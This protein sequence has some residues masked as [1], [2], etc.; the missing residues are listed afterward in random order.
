MRETSGAG[1]ADTE[2]LLEL[3]GEAG[4]L[5]DLHEFRSGLLDLLRR[6]VPADWISV[7]DIGPDPASI[8]VLIDP[9]FPVEDHDVFARLAHENPLISRHARTGDG[10]AYRFSDVVTRAELHAL[11]LYREFYGRI[12]LEHQVAFALPHEQN[13][14]LGVALS[15][16]ERDFSDEEVALLNRARPFLIQAYRNAIA[17]SNLSAELRIALAAQLPPTSG[18]L[19]EQMAARRIT[20]RELEVLRWAAAGRTDGDIADGLGISTRTVQKH[21]ERSFRKL[22]VRT[23]ADAA[24]LVWT[25]AAD[26]AAP[27]A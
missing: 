7:N 6:A 1:S 25:L 2:A 3:V 14:L 4:G 13:R 18:R 24:R 17:Y 10:R 22:A 15:R 5:L 21:L 20:A 26:G 27:H 8:H 19:D 12:G 16:R 11:A 9:P 23:R